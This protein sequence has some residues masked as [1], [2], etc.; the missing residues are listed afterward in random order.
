MGAETWTYAELMEELET[1]ELA[2][3]RANLRASSVRTYIDRS[4]YFIRWLVG[5]YIPR[6]PNK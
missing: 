6:G 3:R 2:L 5:E 1:F 4:Q